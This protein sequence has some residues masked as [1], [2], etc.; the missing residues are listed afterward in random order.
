[1][2]LKNEL[3]SGVQGLDGRPIFCRA[4]H[5][6]ST[7]YFNLQEPSSAS[8]VVVSQKLLDAAGLTYGRDYT[9]CAYVHDEQQLS[10][11]PSEVERVSALLEEAAPASTSS[12]C[13]LQ[14]VLVTAARGK[15]RTRILMPARGWSSWCSHEL[16]LKDQSLSF[17]TSLE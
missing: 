4:E 16:L 10:V 11:V 5:A 14:L 2:Q 1:M 8:V 17:S 9:R 3:S 15:R 13:R 12:R 6:S 7:I